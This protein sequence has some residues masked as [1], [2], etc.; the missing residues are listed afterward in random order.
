MTSAIRSRTVRARSAA[1][2]Q[3]HPHFWIRQQVTIEIQRGRLDDDHAAGDRAGRDLASARRIAEGSQLA[4]DSYARVRL[5]ARRTSGRSRG[6]A[7]RRRLQRRPLVQDEATGRR[8]RVHR[9]TDDDQASA[10]LA[11]VFL[12]EG[13]EVAHRARQAI[14]L[15]AQQCIGLAVGALRAHA[16]AQD[17]GATWLTR[18]GPTPSL[19]RSVRSTSVPRIGELWVAQNPWSVRPEAVDVVQ[20]GVVKPLP[21]RGDRRT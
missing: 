13:P 14:E 19:L 8:P 5:R 20:A 17:A 3:A 15:R 11:E 7:R 9:L 12:Q 16:V 4:S 1:C 2:S 6:R 10:V 18:Q 21:P